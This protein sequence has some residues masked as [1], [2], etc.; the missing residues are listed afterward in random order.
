[1]KSNPASASIQWISESWQLAKENYLIAFGVTFLSFIINIGLNSLGVWSAIPCTIVSVM[2]STGYINI[3]RKV[4]N[5]HSPVFADLF[6][7]FDDKKLFA[8]LIP[9]FVISVVLTIPTIAVAIYMGV[10]KSFEI[11]NLIFLGSSFVT[12]FVISGLSFFIIPQLVE[13]NI[14]L[15]EAFKKSAKAVVTN[16][17]PLTI[18]S[19]IL[20]V[21]TAVSV[22]FL[23]LPLIF[24]INP[25]FVFMGY[26]IYRDCFNVVTAP[27]PNSTPSS[28]TIDLGETSQTVATEGLL[29]H[30][31]QRDARMS[32]KSDS[33][34][35]KA[36]T[37]IGIVC[38]LII[39]API[40]GFFYYKN[41]KVNESLVNEC[42]E[43]NKDIFK[44][45]YD[46]NKA[47]DDKAYLISEA[48]DFKVYEAIDDIANITSSIGEGDNKRTLFTKS[49]EEQRPGTIEQCLK[50]MKPI[51]DC[52]EKDFIKLFFSDFD[53]DIVSSSECQ[54][55]VDKASKTIFAKSDYVQRK[56]KINTLLVTFVDSLI[57]KDFEKADEQFVILKEN[58]IDH[59]IG[60][61]FKRQPTVVSNAPI[62]SKLNKS[63]DQEKDKINSSLLNPE[64]N[65]YLAKKYPEVADAN[66]KSLYEN[67]LGLFGKKMSEENLTVFTAYLK[68]FG[69]KKINK[70]ISV[71]QVEDFIKSNN[72]EHIIAAVNN[73]LSMF[74]TDLYG[75]NLMDTA[76]RTGKLN[77]VKALIKKGYG[78]HRRGNHEK[79][80][81]AT[82]LW[83]K[84]LGIMKYLLKAGAKPSQ[85]GSKS[86]Y[87]DT[88]YQ[89]AMESNS[90]EIIRLFKKYR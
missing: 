40:G 74:R 32:R 17:I 78:I 7:M 11:A 15:L 56:D 53:L 12:L 26:I 23:S 77:L 37:I 47:N 45:A 20:I 16:I 58:K 35:G 10:S 64:V 57:N 50:V 3:S 31:L 84:D 81:L 83:E 59:Y 73:G 2:F 4:L 43:R 90:D 51:K 67:S 79:P 8:K 86:Q 54:V 89:D 52:L 87:S 33:Q 14:G 75:Y 29:N 48:A 28:E 6:Y 70:L 72:E 76:I 5:G 71:K 46:Y 85:K 66:F 24:I 34:V 9:L 65:V 69:A 30:N 88:I 41:K 19:L 49:L 60:I 55:K 44:Y 61:F 63:A 42:A 39:G 82:A 22:V 36:L 80:P 68:T 27:T 1:M 18:F 25:M 38:V 21:V 62:Y 13:E